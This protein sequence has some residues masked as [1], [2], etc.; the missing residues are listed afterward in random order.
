M[1]L[2]Y[3]H[4]R[5]KMLHNLLI[6]LI[7]LYIVCNC[8]AKKIETVMVHAGC[9]PEHNNWSVIPSINLATTFVQEYPGVVSIDNEYLTMFI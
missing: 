7:C 4:F 3:L 1:N 2:D 9:E 6:V 5:L 8:H